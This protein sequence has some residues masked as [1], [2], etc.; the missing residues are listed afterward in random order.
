MLRSRLRDGKRKGGFIT[1]IRVAGSNGIAAIIPAGV[2]GMIC[3][4]SG[5][6]ARYG[7]TSRNWKSIARGAIYPAAGGNG[8][9]RSIGLTIREKFE[10]VLRIN[11]LELSEHFFG[12]GER[13]QR[14]TLA[15]GEKFVP[16]REN[17][18]VLVR[19][20]DRFV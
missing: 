15:S 7:V 1:K 12:F 10:R 17:I 16:H 19:G 4:R 9:P 14:D 6:G 13:F 5:D 11:R 2:A 3:D 18:R 8:R 20:I